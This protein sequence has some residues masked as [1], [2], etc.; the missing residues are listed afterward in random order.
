MSNQI[1]QS[2]IDAAHGRK[3]P[4]RA[5]AGVERSKIDGRPRCLDCGIA[6]YPRNWYSPVCYCGYEWPPLPAPPTE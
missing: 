1:R 3:S 2:L 5:A 4:E 6:R